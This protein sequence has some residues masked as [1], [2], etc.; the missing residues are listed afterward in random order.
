MTLGLTLWVRGRKKA[1]QINPDV[2]PTPGWIWGSREGRV[3]FTGNRKR[4][5]E[6]SNS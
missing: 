4:I 3:S 6:I 1:C 2:K 5:R